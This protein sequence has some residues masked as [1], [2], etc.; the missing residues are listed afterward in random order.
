[1]K[2]LKTQKKLASQIM[3]CSPKKVRFDVESLSEVKESITKIDLKG[4]IGRGV[5]TKK[6]INSASRVRA[7]KKLKQKR[8]G[9]QKGRGSRKG[10]ANARLS[11]KNKWMNKVRKQRALLKSLKDTKL[12]TN[13]TYR[14]LSNKTKGGFFRSVKHIKIYLDENKLFVKK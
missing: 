1:M 14:G 6:P 10:T 5:V 9:L 4:L 7:R 8:K 13:E 12:I 2:S 3:K 11:R